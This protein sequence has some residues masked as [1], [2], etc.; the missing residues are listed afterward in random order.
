[1]LILGLIIFFWLKKKKNQRVFQSNYPVSTKKN[2][3]LGFSL[4]Y[5]KTDANSD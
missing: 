1:M 2:V 4:E 3:N 5:F